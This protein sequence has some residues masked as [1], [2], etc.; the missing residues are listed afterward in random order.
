MHFAHPGGQELVAAHG[1]EDARLAHE[2]DEQHAGD[3]G[4]GTRGHEVRGPVLLDL[5]KR[6]RRAR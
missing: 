4:H 3:A 5:P 6:T 2:H 1:E